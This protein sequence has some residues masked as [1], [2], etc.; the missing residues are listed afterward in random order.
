MLKPLFLLPKKAVKIRTN[1]RFDE[2]TNPLFIS[3]GLFKFFELVKLEIGSY[4]YKPQHNNIF[5]KLIHIYNT[6]NRNDLIAPIHDLSIFEKSLAFQRPKQR[7]NI[8]QN[9]KK[10]K[11]LNLFKKHF[12]LGLSSD[13]I[14]AN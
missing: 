2:H 3:L 11:T 8:S 5:N 14:I 12:K 7:N 10:A 4:I 6:R 9:L 13:C 1:S